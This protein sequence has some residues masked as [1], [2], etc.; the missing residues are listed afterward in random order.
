MDTDNVRR[1]LIGE[2]NIEEVYNNAVQGGVNYFKA[3]PALE[4][5][6]IG[7]S[8]GVDSALGAALA[9]AVRNKLAWEGREIALHG[10][11]IPILTNE[12]EEIHRA[13]LV[14]HEFCDHFVQAT[15]DMEVL[16]IIGRIDNSLYWEHLPSYPDKPSTHKTKIRVGNIK[17][18]YRMMYLY[19]KAQKYNGLVLSTDNYT[20]YLMGFWTLHGDVGDFGFIQEL[21]KT[22]VYTMAE[23]LGKSQS[24]GSLLSC[25]SAKPT[26][27]LGVSDSDLDQ[28]LPGWGGSYRE[29]YS[30][31]DEMLIAYLNGDSYITTGETTLQVEMLMDHPVFKRYFA[32]Q[33]K[34]NNPTNLK[35]S[36]LLFGKENHE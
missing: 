18:R 34:R 36:T 15:R 9:Y 11:S 26:D 20:E 14:G 25:V 32:T 27:G 10:Y 30:C 17:A 1:S 35:R 3:H 4:S 28:L 5:I 22:E 23:W 7:L 12:S 21:W 33:Y 24:K 19:D 6:I 2:S 29:G 13:A 8:G 31:I 16:N